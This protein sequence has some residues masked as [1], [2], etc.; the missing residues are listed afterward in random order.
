[1]MTVVLSITM[2]THSNV[3]ILFVDGIQFW[4]GLGEGDGVI[5]TP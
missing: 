3:G 2:K 4:E 5:N 1:M